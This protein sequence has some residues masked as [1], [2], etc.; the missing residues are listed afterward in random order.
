MAKPDYE[1]ERLWDD[2]V[3]D[4]LL[5]EGKPRRSRG[6]DATAVGDEGEDMAALVRRH[7]GRL[8]GSDPRR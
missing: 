3:W 5:R 6:D 2:A 4:D 8:P 7:G 1:T